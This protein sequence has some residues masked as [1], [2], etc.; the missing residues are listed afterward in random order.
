M[1]EFGPYPL[2]FLRERIAA[3]HFGPRMWI[4]V[5]ED[6]KRICDIRLAA[7]EGVEDLWKSPI[8]KGPEDSDENAS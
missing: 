1:G 5:V 8:G 6:G 7:V 3:G 2:E 4:T